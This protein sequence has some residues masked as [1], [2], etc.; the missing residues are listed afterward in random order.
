MRNIYELSILIINKFNTFQNNKYCQLHIITK[1]EKRHL[2]NIICFM[3][4]ILFICWL[5]VQS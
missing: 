2:K 5:G 1:N 4:L 3:F